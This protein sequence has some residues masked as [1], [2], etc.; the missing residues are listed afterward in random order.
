M[1][2]RLHK[3]LF[4]FVVKPLAGPEI[5]RTA[6]A[7]RLALPALHAA[8]DPDRGSPTVVAD[9]HPGVAGQQR[10]VGPHQPAQGAGVVEKGL[11][12][13]YFWERCEPSSATL[14]LLRRTN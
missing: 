10:V 14:W 3:P 4:Q 7:A 5:R 1:R 13:P 9:G 2:G 11:H 8:I 12:D 6:L